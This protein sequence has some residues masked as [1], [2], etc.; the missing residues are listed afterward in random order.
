MNIRG[1]EALHA[2]VQGGGIAAAA[3]QV[4]R[5]Q[6]QVSRIL[7]QLEDDVGF[8]LLRKEGRR[9]ILT[10]DGSE[11]YR[12]MMGLLEHKDALQVFSENIR[13]KRAHRLHIM[14]ANHMVEA[15][16]LDAIIRAHAQRPELSV[17]INARMPLMPQ[18]TLGGEAFDVVLAQLPID[19]PS[20]DTVE[21][22][23]LDMVAIAPADHRFA[24][25]DAVEAA[26]FE[27]EPYV[28]L[29]PRSLLRGRSDQALNILR[30]RPYYKF[31][32]SFASMTCHL[33]AGGCGVAVADPLAALAHR[34]RGLVIRRFLPRIPLNYGLAFPVTQDRSETS[35]FFEGV[36][37]QVL[38][39]KLA[40]LNEALRMQQA[41]REV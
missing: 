30:N 6:P 38:K 21:L 4:H 35:L 34:H 26:D 37:R 14:A 11:F 28:S 22:L 17:S 33:V 31:E 40:A 3:K 5:T 1:L 20:L 13:L 32:A 39:E 15:F 18:S 16:L 9:L 41:P 19:H 7:A 24:G 29:P 23:T 27:S 25:M 36:I 2:L 12:R 10:Q 8:P